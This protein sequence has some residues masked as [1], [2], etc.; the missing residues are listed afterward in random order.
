M[1][2][3]RVYG[4]NESTKLTNIAICMREHW[5][6]IIPLVISLA[7]I[8]ITIAVVNIVINMAVETKK[9]CK[10]EGCNNGCLIVRQ[11]IERTY[12][13]RG[14]ETDCFTTNMYCINESEWERYAGTSFSHTSG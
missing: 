13:Y 8:V 1:V 14:P 9:K 12:C 11:L 2:K 10:A 7:I 4:K 6:K 5:K 3:I